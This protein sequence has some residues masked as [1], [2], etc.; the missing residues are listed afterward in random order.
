[1]CQQTNK[2]PKWYSRIHNTNT[3]RNVNNSHISPRYR[4]EVR[5]VNM[6]SWRFISFHR[7]AWLRDGGIAVPLLHCSNRAVKCQRYL[8]GWG[9]KCELRNPSW[10]LEW[11]R[12][13]LNTP[14]HCPLRSATLAC[15]VL[16][17]LSMKSSS[18][19]NPFLCAASV[20]EGWYTLAQPLAI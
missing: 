11:S 5:K 14:N 20:R 16:V 2:S 17:C 7:N 10:K 13:P 1:M 8:P 4:P 12:G 18:H 15:F 9:R 6:C 3:R 19:S